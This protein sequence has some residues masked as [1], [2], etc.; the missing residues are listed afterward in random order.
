MAAVQSRWGG[1]AGRGRLHSAPRRSRSCTRKREG[2]TTRSR[3]A[4]LDR[5]Q[6]AE[7]AAKER[8]SRSLGN[9][10]PSFG[11][12]TAPPPAGVGDSAVVATLRLV[13]CEAPRPPLPHIKTKQR[14]PRQQA[15]DV[16]AGPGDQLLQ[17]G[18]PSQRPQRQSGLLSPQSGGRSFIQSVGRKKDST[19]PHCWASHWL[20][21]GSLPPPLRVWGAAWFRSVEEI[22]ASSSSVAPRFSGAVWPCSRLSGAEE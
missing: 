12:C 5:C 17:R 16:L 13:P 15:R 1:G 4:A 21:S 2:R 22:L 18:W 20:G 9:S 8:R 6:G 10:G 3:P 7:A 14:C 11:I 19:Q